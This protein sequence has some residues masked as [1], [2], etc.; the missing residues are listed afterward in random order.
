M[1]C[2]KI[3]IYTLEFVALKHA[4]LRSMNIYLEEIFKNASEYVKI[5]D[6]VYLVNSKYFIKFRTPRQATAVT[7]SDAYE[8]EVHRALEKAKLAVPLVRCGYTSDKK[9]FWMV[10]TNLGRT[11]EEE[12]YIKEDVNELVKTLHRQGF[13]HGDLHLGNI[14]STA[15]GLRLIDFEYT[16]PIRKQLP[17]TRRLYFEQYDMTISTVNDLVKEEKMMF[18]E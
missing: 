1:L 9:Y 15:H 10:T 16:W 4:H 7:N 17:E 3:H 2:E 8:V 12:L 14:I 5:D 6:R 18:N 13:V 11:L